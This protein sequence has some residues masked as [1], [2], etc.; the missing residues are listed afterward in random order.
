M[1]IDHWR[2]IATLVFACFC[3]E[4]W[5]ASSAQAQIT[6]LE[7]HAFSSM[8][9][10]DKQF[11]LGAK[12][13]KPVTLT[14]ELRI[15]PSLNKV[16]AIVLLLASGGFGSNVDR[17]LREFN[18]M[19]IAT[20]AVDSFT[21]RGIE[22]TVSDQDQL[23]R[24][25]LTFDAYRALELLAKHPQIDASRIAVTGFSFGGAA[26]RFT[27][28]K[29]FQRMHGPSGVE[30]AAY[31]PFYGACNTTYIGDT[32]VSGKPILQLH[33]AADDYVP[34]AP[35]R[36][37]FERLK[38]AGQNAVLREYPD[39]HDVFDYELLSPTP[40]ALPRNQT[41]RN[42][43]IKEEMA[44]EVVNAKT[45]KP[46]TFADPCVELGPH[47]GYNSAAT[48]AAVADVKLFLRAALDIK[49]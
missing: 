6:R 28:L 31:V 19:G 34:V 22:T 32:G 20:F 3:V 11:L 1:A 13:G 21:G 44:G 30:F 26:A 24:P 37:Y 23:G 17:W 7:V 12:D 41:S 45:G 38:G 2:W 42:C 33:G 47:V 40:L 25:A 14:G 5:Q 8:T 27:S 18:G 49:E 4:V 48:D 10:T 43:V 15:P 29:R 35:C 39:A 9:L 16:P 36:A 46:F